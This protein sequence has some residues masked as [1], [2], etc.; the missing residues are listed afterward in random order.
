[1]PGYWKVFERRRACLARG[2]DFDMRTQTCAPKHSAP[3]AGP[4]RRERSRARL[5]VAPIARWPRQNLQGL[6]F[7]EIPPESGEV[8]EDILERVD[9][10]E[11]IDDPAQG[12]DIEPEP[13]AGVP[14][15]VVALGAAALAGGGLY[16]ALR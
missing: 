16:F 7:A 10:L 8:E 9:I 13:A 2:M 15:A 3:M 6:G 14:R 11:K 12:P 4:L 1:M 5:H